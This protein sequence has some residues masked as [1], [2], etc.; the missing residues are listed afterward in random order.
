MLEQK[1]ITENLQKT[2]CYK[3]GS[4]LENAKLVP[5]TNAPVAL[6]AHAVC[7]VC[8][9]ESMI[10]ITPTGSG[11]VPVKSD[12]TGKEFKKFIGAKTISYDELLDLHTAL[13]KKDLW[14]LMHKKEKNLEKNQKA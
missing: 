11:T 14:S 13:K 2:L 1:I 6:I 4:S 8:S 7:S 5:I 9:A 12:L 10:T 3:C